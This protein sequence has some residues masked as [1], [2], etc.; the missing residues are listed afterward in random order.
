MNIIIKGNPPHRI[1][2]QR[3]TCRFEFYISDIKRFGCEYTSNVYYVNCPTCQLFLRVAPP[4]KDSD[5]L[6]EYLEGTH[7]EA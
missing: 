2:C 6:F 1:D 7:L 5:A 3:C 4:P